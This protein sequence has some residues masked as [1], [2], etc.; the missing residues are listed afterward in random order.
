MSKDSSF[1]KK[2][3]IFNS[4]DEF[5]KYTDLS[6]RVL[7][8]M[9]YDFNI[10]DPILS[11][12]ILKLKSSNTRIYNFKVSKCSQTMK[13]IFDIVE[14]MDN[15]QID[16]VIAIGEDFLG[17]ILK[18]INVFYN[19]KNITNLI[20]LEENKSN[21]KF[22]RLKE[23][24]FI[25]TTGGGNELQRYFKII[26]DECSQVTIFDNGMA[27][28]D[29]VVLDAKISKLS[30]IEYIMYYLFSTIANVVD[31]ILNDSV[32]DST[33]EICKDILVELMDILKNGDRFGESLLF[34]EKVLN[35]SSEISK[36]IDNVGYG[37]L[38]LYGS[39]IE[40]VFSIPRNTVDALGIEF[41]LN[42]VMKHESISVNFKR[43]FNISG[44]DYVEFIK[45]VKGK[46]GVKKN[47]CFYKLDEESFN[48]L[49]VVAMNF[50]IK[51]KI[52]ER[53]SL[54]EFREEFN[55]KLFDYYLNGV[56]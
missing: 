44:F 21:L 49:K 30:P 19:N 53:Y 42:E 34:R 43:Y 17:E 56:N 8:F 4:Y 32:D 50:L 3:T 2:Q 36:I 28:I 38:Y 40:S 35:Y 45:N 15:H 23:T 24:I 6:D 9:F 31:I 26:D 7:M 52:I 33:K 25:S 13:N 51:H 18:A 41:I 22:D 55:N 16:T 27:K 5:L 39:L 1:F 29:K 12:L 37:I 14:F 46:Y 20:E 54:I 10:D 11:D 48:N 47:L